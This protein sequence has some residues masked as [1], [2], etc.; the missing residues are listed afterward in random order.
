ME[1]KIDDSNLEV[2]Y[3]DAAN[4][5]RKNLS[6]ME[7]AVTNFTRSASGQMMVDFE[8]RLEIA[9]QKSGLIRTLEYSALYDNQ[10][11]PRDVEYT[12]RSESG[13]TVTLKLWLFRV[14]GRGIPVQGSTAASSALITSLESDFSY[15]QENAP[16]Y[17]SLLSQ[18]LTIQRALEQ[19]EIAREDARRIIGNF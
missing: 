4:Q 18:W 2:L 7:A 16:A 14:Q 8:T 9:R 3:R 11:I 19:A 17:G 13:E 10:I 1:N 15:L 5:I 6:E 12:V